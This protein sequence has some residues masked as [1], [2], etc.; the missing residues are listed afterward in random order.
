MSSMPWRLLAI[1]IPIALMVVVLICFFRLL[2]LSIPYQDWVSYE[3]KKRRRRK[4]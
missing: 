2:F 1:V 3:R 4:K